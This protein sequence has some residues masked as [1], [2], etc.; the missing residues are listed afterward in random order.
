MAKKKT[1]F[2]I[3]Y[4]QT[5]IAAVLDELERAG[6]KLL[7]DVRAVAASRRPGFSKTQLA[8]GLNERN[9][10]YIHL[11]DLGTPKEGRLAARSGHDDELERIYLAHLATPQARESMDELATLVRNAGPVCILCYERDHKHCH[12]RFIAEVIEAREK[13]TTKNLIAA[14]I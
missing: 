6:V 8:A 13:T 3:G 7:V 14:Q 5:P 10:S 12:R 11:R 1:L 9:I 2:T 4:E